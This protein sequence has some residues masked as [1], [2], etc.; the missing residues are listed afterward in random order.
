MSLK[1]KRAALIKASYFFLLTMNM[2][3]YDLMKQ[4]DR[5]IST[6]TKKMF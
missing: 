3:S 2:K 1:K 6:R 5:S 4:C